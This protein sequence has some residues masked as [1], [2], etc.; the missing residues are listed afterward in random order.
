MAIESYE[1][2]G[3]LGLEN[4]PRS[5]LYAS[6]YCEEPQAFAIR[7][8]SFFDNTTYDIAGY[9]ADLTP[10]Q[11]EDLDSGAWTFTHSGYSLAG[12]TRYFVS[13]ERNGL[14]TQFYTEQG[15]E[16]PI[17][18]RTINAGITWL[19]SQAYYPYAQVMSIN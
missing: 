6:E 5:R 14:W 4:Y 17:A 9:L 2:I 16:F 11:T 1:A 8:V 15:C 3:Y 13:L 10:P 19:C 18:I 12:N 7:P